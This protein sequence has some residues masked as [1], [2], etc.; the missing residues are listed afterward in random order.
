M[1]NVSSNE[2]NVAL[3]KSMYAAL[4]RGDIPSILAMC[5]PDI[6]WE[7]IGPAKDFPL[8]GARRGRAG[9][10][11]FFRD[12]PE[13]HTFTE[14]SPENFIA[15]GD[16]VVVLGHYSFTFNRNSRHVATEWAH[17][18]TIRDGK[19]AKFRE[20]TDTAQMVEAYRMSGGGRLPTAGHG[21]T[22]ANSIADGDAASAT[23]R[24]KAR[25][26]RWVEDGWNKH[27]PA[28]IDEIYAADVRQHDANG[29]PVNNAAELKS[30]VAAL[31]AGFP[32]LEFTIESLAAEGDRVILRFGWRGSHRGQFA[33]I[34]ATGKAAAATGLVEFRFAG[35]RVAEVWVTYDLFGILQQL[36][37]IP[38]AA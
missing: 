4:G 38:A 19:L 23:E 26:R 33:N 5:S 24:N 30:Y 16:T 10:E 1:K 27:N 8:L 13:V 28:L 35:D 20:Y 2:A 34:P 17:A 31:I 3:V 18:F 15:G 22:T 11:K 37:V 7:V 21:V 14:F 25:I 29:M 12:L 32:D 6:D 9:V 36:G